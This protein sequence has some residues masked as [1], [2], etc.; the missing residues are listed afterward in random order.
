MLTLTAELLKEIE[1]QAA[2]AYPYEGC[3]LLLG[4]AG[5]GGN[6]ALALAPLPNRWPAGDERRTRF[7][8]AP[9][10]A[11]AAELAAAAQGLDVVGVYHSHPDHPPLASPRDVAWAAW[12]G[13]SYLITE[14]RAGRP[15]ASRSWQLRP[16]RSGFAAEEIDLAQTAGQEER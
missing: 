7:H 11:L 13:Y 6:Q 2:A 1:A 12:P 16:D 10:D 3:G 15:A 8:I 9:E 14:V 5:D 4:R